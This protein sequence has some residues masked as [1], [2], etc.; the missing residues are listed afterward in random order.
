MTPEK[1]CLLISNRITELGQTPPDRL[2]I[3]QVLVGLSLLVDGTADPECVFHNKL[4]V[5]LDDL[6]RDAREDEKV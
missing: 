6:A 4:H 3:R 5:V 2:V 1:V